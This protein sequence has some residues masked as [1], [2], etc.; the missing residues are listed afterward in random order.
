MERAMPKTSKELRSHRW[1]GVNDLRSF[2]HRSRIKQLGYSEDDFAGK[3]VIGIINTYN[4][5]SPCHGHFPQRVEEIKRGVLQA[6]GFPL[7]LPAIGLSENF[8]KPSTMLYRNLLAMETEELLRSYPIDGAVLMGGCD[9]TTPGLLMGAISMDVPAVYFP[10]GPMLSGCWKGQTLGSGSDVWK[11][12][13]ELRAGNIS[14]CE[15]KGM[16]NGIARSPGHCMTMG[17]A[18]TMTAIAEVLG[19][20]LPG[21]SSV[22]AVMTDQSRLAAASGRLAVDAV[23]NDRT[24]STVMSDEAVHNAAVVALAMGGSTN[25]IIHLVAMGKRAGLDTN[26]DLFDALATRVPLL[27]N[28][29]PAGKYLM[30]DFYDAGGILGLLNR[31]KSLLYLEAPIITGGTLGDSVVDAEVYDSEIIRGID[32]PVSTVPALR[33]LRGNLCPDGA[34][35]KPASMDPEKMTHVGSAL[36]FDSYREYKEQIDDPTLDI[37]ENT[38]LILRG[39]GPVGAPGMPEWGMMPLPK[40]LVENGVRDMVRI[41]DARMSGTSYGTCILHV[42]PESAVG[43]PLAAVRT[44]DL[45]ELDVAAGTINA[46]VGD[47]DWAN[48]LE[49]IMPAELGHERGYLGLYRRHVNQADQGCDFDFLA[50]IGNPEPEIL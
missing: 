22:P 15:W 34:V 38:V 2:G 5:I 32:N 50:G 6:G 40:K 1:F 39:S 4:D 41:S 44:G 48:R 20:S 17:T 8:Q 24:P 45:I 47:D 18:S 10:S 26:N 33:L 28:I 49:Q 31:L 11:Y 42:A 35:I 29:R 9:K 46:M 19:F 43:G 16:E 25:A 37:D 14:E 12:W 30:Q 13:D 3:P 23:W 27:A 7:E 36:V 21:A